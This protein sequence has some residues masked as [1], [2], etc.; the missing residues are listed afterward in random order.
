VSDGDIRGFPRT[1][2]GGPRTDR[3][4]PERDRVYLTHACPSLRAHHHLIE[5]DCDTTRSHRDT[6]EPKSDVASL[7]R[8]AIEMARDTI[9]QARALRGRERDATGCDHSTR[10]VIGAPRE[11][12]ATRSRT[13]ALSTEPN[14]AFQRPTGLLRGA[15]DAPS[16]SRAAAVG[17]HAAI[18]TRAT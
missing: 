2:R 18:W 9:G 4:H 1:D 6:L 15:R 7:T 17:A 3:E 12:R 14:A 13:I 10:S 8:D 11:R 16:R 5:R